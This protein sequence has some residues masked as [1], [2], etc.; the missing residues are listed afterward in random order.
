MSNAKMEGDQRIEGAEYTNT[1]LKNLAGYVMQDDLLNANFT[2][3]ETLYYCAELRL[4]TTMTAAQKS[5]RIESVIARLGL[6]N[7]RDVM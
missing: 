1:Q 3:F 7:C 2:A 6:K 4:P 5:A